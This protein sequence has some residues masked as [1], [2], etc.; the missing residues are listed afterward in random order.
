M[1]LLPVAETSPSTRSPAVKPRLCSRVT[2]GWGPLTYGVP[3]SVSLSPLFEIRV[4]AVFVKVISPV[5][6]LQNL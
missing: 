1:V 5:S 2:D 6:E 4:C 3:L